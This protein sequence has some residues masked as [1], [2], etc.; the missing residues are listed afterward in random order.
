MPIY[1]Q[2]SA[3]GETVPSLGKGLVYGM[4]SGSKNITPRSLKSVEVDAFQ[5]GAQSPRDANS[6]LAAGKRQHQ[7]LTIT[8]EVDAGSPL[9]FTRVSNNNLLQRLNIKLVKTNSQGKEAPYC[10]ISLTNATIVNYK[11]YSAKSFL[12]RPSTAPAP[13]ARELEEISFAFQKIE[14]SNVFGGV[15]ATDDWLAG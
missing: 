6:G 5:Y 4:T 13:S 7:P 9:F 11:R 1:V 14:I 3:V 12:Q 10:T 8:K 2:Y 15:S